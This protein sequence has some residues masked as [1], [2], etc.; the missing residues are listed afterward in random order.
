MPLRVL[1]TRSMHLDLCLA[2]ISK[3]PSD[4]VGD[5][6]FVTDISGMRYRN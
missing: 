3:L 5:E 6:Q 1:S 2:D 4:T